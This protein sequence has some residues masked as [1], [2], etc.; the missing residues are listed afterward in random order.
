MLD[1]LIHRTIDNRWL[2]LGLTLILVGCG[3]FAATHLPVDAY[4]DISPQKAWIITSYPGRAPEEVERQVTIPIEIA[5]RNIPCVLDMRSDTIFGLSAI[6]LVFEDGVDTLWARS[7]VKERLDQVE[8][9]D[10]KMI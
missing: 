6:Y 4:P 5:L 9:P 10:E 1:P 3:L 2:V 8:L 7:Q